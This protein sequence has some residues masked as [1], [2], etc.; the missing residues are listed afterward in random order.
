MCIE[1]QE[2]GENNVLW[3]VLHTAIAVTQPLQ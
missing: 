2:I 1:F 3:V